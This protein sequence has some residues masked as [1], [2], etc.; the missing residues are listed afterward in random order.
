MGRLLKLIILFVVGFFIG[1]VVSSCIPVV[2]AGTFEDQ[3]SARSLE[4]IAT[5]LE[6]IDAS[7]RTCRR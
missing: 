6:H 7:L 1:L 5:S 3:R 4:R 2:N